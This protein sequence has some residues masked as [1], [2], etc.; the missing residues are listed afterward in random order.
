VTLIS[1][2]WISLAILAV[3]T[4][5]SSLVVPGLARA[6]QGATPA[7]G[8]EAGVTVSTRLAE[9]DALVA[10]LASDDPRNREVASTALRELD[11]SWLDAID[12]RVRGLASHRPPVET[13]TLALAEI[14]RTTGSRRA[15]DPVD[16]ALG[17]LPALSTRRDLP[18]VATCESVLLWRALEQV[19]TARSLR[20]VADIV[21]LDGTAWEQ[22]T[23]RTVERLGVRLGPMLIE[24]RSHPS[25][26]VR[27]WS[28]WATAEL[29]LD[30]PGRAIQ[31]PSVAGDT[32]LLANMLRAWGTAHDLNAMRVVVSFVGSEHGEVRDAARAAVEQF[33]R[34]AIWIV[35]E[36][37]AL[38]SGREAD[39]RWGWERTHRALLDAHDE[40]RLAPVRAELA[41][42]EA[43]AA[44]GEWEA[45]GA[46]FDRV[47]LRAPELA[48]RS[49]MADGYARLAAFRRERR[50]PIGAAQEFRRAV[51]LAAPGDERE[52]W[53]T[54]LR[55]VQADIDLARGLVDLHAYRGRLTRDADDSF[56]ATVVARL[57]GE[58][59]AASKQRRRVAAA[60][61]AVLALLGAAALLH[62]RRRGIPRDPDPSTPRE[63]AADDPGDTSP[64]SL[65]AVV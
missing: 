24:V 41:L 1:K 9:L 18:M 13:I 15:D 11:E 42:G 27:R 7:N 52:R 36:Q 3:G 32:A 19:G 22:E 2:H 39:P 61:G 55:A 49:Q 65:G 28:R 53:L 31:L 63:A 25:A 33:G 43:A 37:L 45:M 48:Q 59:P 17:V 44:R 62:R 23:H 40:A 56:A 14:R 10:Q 51:A 58:R 30:Q 5:G 26:A 54:D 29:A 21:A 4:W 35:R 20:L 38:V 16:L 64:G 6:Q 12:A 8:S 50:D 46:R 60:G 47:L 34:N 57:S